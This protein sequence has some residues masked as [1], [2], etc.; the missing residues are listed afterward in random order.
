VGGYRFGELQELLSAYRGL[1]LVENPDYEKGMLSSIQHGLKAVERDFFITPA[2]MPGIT[3]EHY[4]RLVN[5]FGSDKI[6]R[7]VYEQ[8]P[9]HPILCP[10]R[11]KD[12]IL[13]LKGE[14]LFAAFR[15]WDQQQISWEDSSSVTDI[16]TLDDLALWRSE[17]V[18]RID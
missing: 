4:R 14:R 11:Y 1:I 16:D 15:N 10:Y 17:S 2:D 5:F 18:N 6:V 8:T 3:E 9:G 13:A 12:Q 7:L